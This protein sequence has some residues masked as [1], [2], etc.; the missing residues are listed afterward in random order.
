HGK[1]CGS[2]RHHILV[3]A[4]GPGL[5]L[6]P[7]GHVS[8]DDLLDSLPPGVTI[9]VV[10]MTDSDIRELVN[11]TVLTGGTFVGV[12]EDG[13]STAIAG[14]LRAM[15]NEFTVSYDP[16][17]H[18]DGSRHDGLLNV[19]HSVLDLSIPFGYTEPHTPPPYLNLTYPGGWWHLPRLPVGI[20]ISGDLATLE[21][22][23]R[24]APL[25]NG[26]VGNWSEWINTTIING[27]L[28]MPLTDGAYQVRVR[29]SSTSGDTRGWTDESAGNV[30][31]V[32][33]TPPVFEG[34]IPDSPSWD[35][36]RIRVWVGNATD[37]TSGIERL[38]ILI[39]RRAVIYN[40]TISWNGTGYPL[41]LH[42]AYPPG[43][44][45]CTFVVVSGSGL[46]NTSAGIVLIDPSRP[47]TELLAPSNW[48][49][50]GHVMLTAT[51]GGNT[52]DLTLQV[53]ESD[54]D[55]EIDPGLAN[56][57][58][59]E[60]N[61]DGGVNATL[62]IT[63]NLTLE[64]MHACLFR[65]GATN[66]QTGLHGDWNLSEPL[67]VDLVAPTVLQA[68][69]TGGR[70][71][72]TLSFLATDDG[73]GPAAF[74]YEVFRDDESV[75]S[76]TGATN[77][78]GEVSIPGPFG[79][80]VY[81][82]EVWVEDMAGGRSA[83]RSTGEL[84]VSE[85]PPTTPVLVS[86]ADGALVTAPPTLAWNASVDPDGDAVNYDLTVSGPVGVIVN[87]TLTGTSF[88]L[89]DMAT[90]TYTWSVRS[91]DGIHRSEPATAT[92]T[93]DLPDLTGTF[94]FYRDG[95]VTRMDLPGSI[96]VIATVT[97]GGLID[98]GAFN[99]TFTADGRE[100]HDSTI[101]G[102]PAGEKTTITLSVTF[103]RGVHE[104]VMTVDAD[105]DVAED[106]EGNNTYSARFTVGDVSV[107]GEGAGAGADLTLLLALIVALI[108][109]LV[110]I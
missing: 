50:A 39:S 63:Y 43:V 4:F 30:T 13:L 76:G 2:G 94:I 61:G 24:S 86:P 103:D 32:D 16:G 19:T 14:A 36:T 58:T 9:H 66:P 23:Y 1:A 21:V 98:A 75:M 110:A 25:T 85:G 7:E 68:T 106:D 79:A 56:W 109:L 65:A 82:A 44:F 102:L 20:E 40:A 96:I 12:D 48:T 47:A 91:T 8:Y 33:L 59:L 52:T 17:L 97:N 105:D 10:A 84:T 88:T 92:F 70:D 93:Y 54:A 28:D 71:G 64:H 18:L 41:T 27:T 100:V 22:Q 15:Q 34:V 29:G 42:G 67:L 80:G 46:T 38:D 78:T 45:N 95:P 108:I 57:T 35:T 89:S 49:N 77:G 5:A 72:M 107:G 104:V 73:S 101:D 60:V 6:H 55:G 26:T 83:V 62:E 31:L 74:G 53:A 11:L 87:R 3:V 51:S 37:P 90:G 99:L 81:R 69:L